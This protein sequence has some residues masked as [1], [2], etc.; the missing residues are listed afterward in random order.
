MLRAYKTLKAFEDT[1]KD[2]AQGIGSVVE[3]VSNV[4][5]EA[6]K[7]VLSSGVGVM[8]KLDEQ[9]TNRARAA[10]HAALNKS[11]PVSAAIE[12]NPVDSTELGVDMLKKLEEN[13]FPVSKLSD[14]TYPAAGALGM[15][16]E[17]AIDPL[18]H[19]DKL[20]KVLKLFKK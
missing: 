7:T 2:V 12:N 4:M 13:K 9:V 5:P 19:V 3:G 14:G 20:S 16:M 17:L 6:L 11:N 8:G 15:G 18:M 1:N 10:A